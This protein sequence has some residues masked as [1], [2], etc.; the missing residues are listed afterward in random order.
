[1][2]FLFPQKCETQWLT[3]F[4]QP[5]IFLRLS[6]ILIWFMNVS[7]VSTSAISIFCVQ[8]VHFDGAVLHPPRCPKHEILDRSS[9][10][11][12]CQSETFVLTVHIEFIS[13]CI[14]NQN[15]FI[16]TNTT[17]SHHPCQKHFPLMC[18]FGSIH[19]WS[20]KVQCQGWI[21]DG[22]DIARRKGTLSAFWS[23]QRKVTFLRL[24]YRATPD[25][26]AHCCSIRWKSS[27]EMLWHTQRERFSTVPT[28]CSLCL[29]Q[30]V[31]HLL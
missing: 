16:P 10:S 4:N 24:N 15:M 5:A 23:I 1:M 27:E 2:L 26:D 8:C 18:S 31:G 12:D 30:V 20:C 28:P 21:V 6:S 9:I 17:S 25:D 19:F 11:L 14:S 3:L 22:Q 13:V 29:V 7:E